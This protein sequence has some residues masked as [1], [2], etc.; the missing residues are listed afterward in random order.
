M[1]GNAGFGL[2]FEGS[3]GMGRNCE[4]IDNGESIVHAMRT[5][6]GALP[7]QLQRTYSGCKVLYLM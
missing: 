2:G 1:K 6:E 4:A 5:H 3:E 7:R